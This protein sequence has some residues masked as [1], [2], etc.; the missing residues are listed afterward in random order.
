MG[1]D[2]DRGFHVM[3]FILQIRHLF[4]FRSH[5][6]DFLESCQRQSRLAVVPYSM[7]LCSIRSPPWP[8]PGRTPSFLGIEYYVIHNRRREEKSTTRRE[9][10]RCQEKKIFKIV[11]EQLPSGRRTTGIGNVL[12]F[13]GGV[14]CLIK[15]SRRTRGEH[16]GGG[17]FDV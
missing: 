5:N 12:F 3:S 9:A 11:S 15:E 13:F 14:Y 2:S 4:S 16:E 1:A 10:R 8:R 7:I 6:S 17:A